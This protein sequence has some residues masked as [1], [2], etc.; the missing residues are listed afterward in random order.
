VRELREFRGA[1]A[2]FQRAGV[3]LA[4]VSTD[5]LESHQWWT[6][7]L[8]LP[9]PL[10][11]DPARSAGHALGLVRRLG[12][13]G[14]SIDLFRRATLLADAEGVIVA[15]WT[16][17]RIRRHAAEVLAAARSLGSGPATPGRTPPADPGSA[18]GAGPSP[19]SG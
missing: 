12:I 15:A 10:L 9:Y 6:A 19:P 18:T 1:F 13:G 5:T 17:V 7:R 8:H 16:A 2:D 3:A 11:S 14:W 4:G